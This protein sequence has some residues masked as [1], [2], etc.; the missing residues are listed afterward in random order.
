MVQV[1]WIYG[2]GMGGECVAGGDGISELGGRGSVTWEVC[3]VGCGCV[4]SVVAAGGGD[5]LRGV[6]RGEDV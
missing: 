6:A 1:D 3:F 4:C 5:V 2:E